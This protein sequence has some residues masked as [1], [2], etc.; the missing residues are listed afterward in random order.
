MFLRYFL[1]GSSLLF[2]LVN[3]DI[4]RKLSVALNP[5]CTLENQCSD[6]TVV[7]IKSQAENDTIHYIWDFTGIPAILIA[8][9]DINTTMNIDWNNFIIGAPNS[10]QF[11]SFPRY[12]FSSFLHRIFVF[13]DPNDK[14]NI[15]DESVSNVISLHPH[16]NF[17]WS[18]ENLTQFDNSVVLLMKAKIGKSNDSS[19]HMKVS[20]CTRNCKLQR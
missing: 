3:C 16:S 18:R 20:F 8:K 19:V 1:I 9:T 7:Y 2:C 12:V 5:N 10:V 13:D 4:E 15:A 17:V 11:S 6:F 14:A